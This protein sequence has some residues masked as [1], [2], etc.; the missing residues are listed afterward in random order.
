[1]WAYYLKGSILIVRSSNFVQRPIVRTKCEIASLMWTRYWRGFNL[2]GQTIGFHWRTSH[3]TKI[4]RT[5][6]A[7]HKQIQSCKLATD[8]VSFEQPITSQHYFYNRNKVGTIFK[9]SLLLNLEVKRLTLA[10]V[11]DDCSFLLWISGLFFRVCNRRQFQGHSL[12]ITM[13]F[14]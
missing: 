2:N 5:K 4:F 13:E 3:W 14:F 7:K 9:M 1:M 10:Q 11:S 12:L 6:S 8:K